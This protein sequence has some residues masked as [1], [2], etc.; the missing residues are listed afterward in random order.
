[1]DAIESKIEAIRD[2]RLALIK[3]QDKERQENGEQKRLQEEKQ[4]RIK[5]EEKERIE[6]LETE[7]RIQEARKKEDAK[8]LE[9]IRKQREEEKILQSKKQ[10]YTESTVDIEMI[11]VEG[12]TFTMG[13]S[14]L[15]FIGWLNGDHNGKPAHQVTL[16]N[17]YIGKYPVTQK[18]WTEIMGSNPSSNQKY[19]DCYR[20]PVESVSWNEVQ[21]FIKKLNE[22]T[23]KTYRLPTEAEWEY[24]ARGGKKSRGY[25]YSGSD[26]IEEVAWYKK[27]R[28]VTTLPVGTKK[29]NELGIYDMSG[30]VY[31]W[32]KDWFGYYTKHLQT[33]PKGAN[34]GS[35]HVIRGGSWVDKAKDCRV[36]VRFVGSPDYRTAATGFRLAC[37]LK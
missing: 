23:G 2:E 35:Q 15:G 19:A 25:K 17:Y 14:T 29:S 3:K 18:Q 26:N 28:Q 37:D 13:G 24:A 36:C 22:I 21:E 9:K 12:G 8:L 16:N 20:C 1:M 34:S 27:N 31:E 4:K 7:R 32:C 10:N 6:K 30:N 33:N 5:Q 11:F